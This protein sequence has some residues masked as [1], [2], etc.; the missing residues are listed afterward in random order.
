MASICFAE[1]KVEGAEIT[2]SSWRDLFRIDKHLRQ[3]PRCLDDIKKRSPLSM[4]R[5]YD[6]EARRGLSALKGKRKNE[7]MISSV[8]REGIQTSMGASGVISQ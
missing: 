3:Q 7:H 4:Y 1:R 6:T 5:D 8:A 2:V